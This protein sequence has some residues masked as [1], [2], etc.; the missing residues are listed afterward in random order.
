MELYYY[1]LDLSTMD[2]SETYN[3]NQDG[4]F[5]LTTV[6]QLPIV[7][8]LPYYNSVAP[9]DVV[10]IVINGSVPSVLGNTVNTNSFLVEKLTGVTVNYTRNYLVSPL[11][12]LSV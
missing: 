11:V 3:V 10:N 12:F 5:N 4:Y 2:Q 6:L 1:T 8:S 7:A 9:E